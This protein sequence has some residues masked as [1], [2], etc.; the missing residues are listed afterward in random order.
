MDRSEIEGE[1]QTD[2]MRWQEGATHRAVEEEGI[3]ERC[4]WI[5]ERLRLPTGFKEVRGVSTC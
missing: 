1:E 4:E 2:V 5:S 3:R